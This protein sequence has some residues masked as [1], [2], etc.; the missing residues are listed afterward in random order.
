MGYCSTLNV[1]NSTIIHRILTKDV[2]YKVLTW[3]LHSQSRKN[4]LCLKRSESKFR[5]SIQTLE[6]KLSDLYGPVWSFKIFTTKVVALNSSCFE[7]I[8]SISLPFKDTFF[9]KIERVIVKLQGS[10]VEEIPIHLL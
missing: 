3:R 1:D 4:I 6:S 8:I 10:I 7:D 9:V 5:N 2:L